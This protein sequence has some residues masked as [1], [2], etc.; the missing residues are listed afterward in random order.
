MSEAD[1]GELV[2][3]CTLIALIVLATT[4]IYTQDDF[5]YHGL[6]VSLQSLP[7]DLY[8]TAALRAIEYLHLELGCRTIL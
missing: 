4:L 1:Y 2:G 6:Y 3:I 8:F 7:R 5:V